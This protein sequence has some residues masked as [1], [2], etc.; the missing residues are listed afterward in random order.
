MSPT[1]ALSTTAARSW[2]RA[3]LRRFGRPALVATLTLAETGIA[4][5]L[6]SDF[7][8]FASWMLW[9][10][11]RLWFWGLLFSAG[12]LGLGAAVCRL[13]WR[14]QDVPRLEKWALAAAVGAV[15]FGT[16][17]V[18]LGAL[19]LYHPAVAVLLPVAG[20]A[21]GLGRS[22]L[23]RLPDPRRWTWSFDPLQLAVLAFG[24]LSLALIYLHVLN[25]SA[26]NYDAG[27]THLVIGQDYAREGR[28][29]PAAEWAKDFP[30]LASIFYTWVFLGPGLG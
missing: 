25:P 13:A 9:K 27:W 21:A 22:P 10:L 7:T 2:A 6:L 19:R 11:L 12:C 4:V 14:D 28:I 29:V 17:M 26:T 15:A 30:H 24:A 5:Y 3:A 8:S 18:V 1:F 23:A 16:T 20:I